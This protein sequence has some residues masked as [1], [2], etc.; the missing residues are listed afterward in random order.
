MGNI[1]SVG[2]PNGILPP[3]HIPTVKNEESLKKLRMYANSDVLVMDDNEPIVYLCTT[4]SIGTLSYEAY[5]MVKRKTKEQ[6]KQEQQE[7]LMRALTLMNA[8]L[9]KLEA[10]Y[11]ES[12]IAKTTQPE[13]VTKFATNQSIVEEPNIY[14]E[15]T[16]FN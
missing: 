15:P 9:E 7:Q 10:M 8:R 5:D 11:D 6:E 16:G 13:S 14:R 4:D 1:P 12:N 3:Q 2:I